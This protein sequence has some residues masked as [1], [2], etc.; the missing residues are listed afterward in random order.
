MNNLKLNKTNKTLFSSQAYKRLSKIILIIYG[1]FMLMYAFR[2]NLYKLNNQ[3]ITLFAWTAPNLIPSFI[4]T[5]IGIFYVVP[6]LFKATDVI[7]NSKF[8][9]LINVLNMII[10]ALIEYLHVIFKVGV[11][12][13]K[14]MVASLIGIVIATIVYFK[15]RKFFV[16]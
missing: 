15:F 1:L 7:N 8:I 6:M 16:S 4:F 13:N 11:W 12:D 10:F 14:D 3:Y 9:W 2:E 5:L